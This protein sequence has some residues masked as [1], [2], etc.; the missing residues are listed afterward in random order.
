MSNSSLII[1]RIIIHNMGM[2]FC[3]NCK[4]IQKLSFNRHKETFIFNEIIELFAFEKYFKIRYPCVFLY[5][6]KVVDKSTF[7][8]GNHEFVLSSK[9]QSDRRFGGEKHHSRR[10][11]K[12]AMRIAGILD[13]HS[14][15]CGTSQ[16]VAVL[17]NL[18]HSGFGSDL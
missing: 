5:L 17:W 13:W 8:A 4:A 2:V 7:L 18:H 1:Y 6:K 14:P 10:R 12:M 16:R 11:V 15:V 3:I 9:L